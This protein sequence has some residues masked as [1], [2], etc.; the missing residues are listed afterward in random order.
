MIQI[1]S[2]TYH[3]PNAHRPALTDVQMQINAGEFVLIAGESGSGKSTLLRCLNGLVPHFSGGTISGAVRVNGLDPIALGVTALSGHVGFV[4]Q[5][6]EAQAVL[7]TVEADI[8]FGLENAAIAPAEMAAR[9]DEVMGLLGLNSLRERPLTTLSGGE[10]QRVA[11]ASALALRPQI[12]ALDEP[13]SQL[14]PHA[15][16]DLLDALVHL[17]KQV[18]L[19]IVLVEHRLERVL[20][21]VD[22]MIWMENGRVSIDAP[23]REAIA[24]AP[25]T[26]PLQQL[27]RRL[28]W[29]PLPLTVRE[30]RQ[31]FR[32]DLDRLQAKAAVTSKV[33]ATLL[34]VNGLTFGYDKPLLRDV[35][36]TVGAGEA[37][38]LLGRNG[39]GKSTLLRCLIGLLKVEKG[40]VAV[41]GRLTTTLDTA[42]ICREAAYLPQNPDDLLFANSV[43]D[44][45]LITL[46][47]HKLPPSDL[48]ARTLAG[49]G[50]ASLAAAY[51]RDLSV[52]QRQR[53]A[54]GA[55]TVT[56]PSLLLLD[57]PTRGLDYA[58]KQQLVTIWRR[59]LANGMGLLLVT[60]DVELAALI[61][62]RTLILDE[63]VIV[64]A[65][66]TAVVL[67]NTPDF[68]PQMVR[69]LPNQ[70][71]L[72]V[73]EIM[74]NEKLMMDN[75]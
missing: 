60:H 33:T 36:F 47:N 10:R 4:L 70:G 67:S 43:A 6:P 51:P 15:A 1:K 31:K 39:S 19:T 44:E 26:P 75:G 37:V 41:N 72:T 42:D 49:L 3:Y 64:A 46:Q 20:P 21:F 14:D 29:S 69:L 52:G 22:R 40:T 68:A 55:I 48:I 50:L 38:A 58:A 27:G 32:T 18:G 9:V 62:D 56:R 13:T 12:L 74:D 2:L 8:A 53:V 73:E 54:L 34:N 65:G 28:G 66:K 17:N 11:I 57:E 16:A 59:W 24:I 5:T 61:A 45:L 25:Q 30:A 71:I 23:A 35:N 63:G 7:D